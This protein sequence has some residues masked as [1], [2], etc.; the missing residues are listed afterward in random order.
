[1]EVSSLVR[2][3]MIQGCLGNV[4]VHKSM[5]PSGMHPQV[6][7]KLAE[8]IA[9]LLSIISERSWRMGEVPERWRI[10]SVTPAFKN[11]KK[12]DLGNYRPVSLTSIPE[13]RTE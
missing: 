3:E 10:A 9:E 8:V 1:M 5:C 6:L 2:E 7:R 11:D 12:E 13:K 4:S